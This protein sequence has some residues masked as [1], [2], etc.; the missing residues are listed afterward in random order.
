MPLLDHFQ[1]PMKRRLPWSALHS[2]WATYL[3]SNLVDRWLPA[4]FI[5]VEHTRQGTEIEIDVATYE[6]SPATAASGNGGVATH[7]RTWTAPAPLA[8]VPI[9]F[10]DSFE[11]LVYADEAGWELVG[12]IELV[13]PKNKDRTGPP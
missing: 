6:T 8:S 13:S 5:A 7:S 10:P 9:E 11:V 2:G 12:A 3:A 4:P 1:D